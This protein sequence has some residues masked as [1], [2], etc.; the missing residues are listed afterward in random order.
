M[1]TMCSVW[2][3]VSTSCGQNYVDNL[4]STFCAFVFCLRVQ[5]S[6]WQCWRQH[7]VCLLPVDVGCWC[8]DNVDVNI[9]CV[10]VCLVSAGRSNCWRCWR[11][12]FVCLLPV[13]AGFDMLTLLTSTI[14]VLLCAVYGGRQLVDN[15]D[16]NIFCVCYQLK[17]IVNLLTMLTSTFCVLVCSRSH[18]S[19]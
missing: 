15:V 7:F 19:T 18:W 6:C 14:Y 8:V 10:C 17:R 4:T 12:H 9:L 13:D 11:Q 3:L 1:S 5:S 16:V 2:V